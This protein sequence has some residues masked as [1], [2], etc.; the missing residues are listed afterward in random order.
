VPRLP[1][2]LVALLALASGCSAGEMRT[3]RAPTPPGTARVVR[4]VDGDTVVVDIDGR[5]EPVRLIGIDTPE[6]VAE[7]RPVECYGP[8]A[9]DRMAAL[10]RRG[11]L[12]RLERDVEARDRYDRLLAYVVR[13]EDGLFVNERLVEE[14][15]AESIAYPPNT[16]RQAELDRAEAEAR[17]AQRGLWAACGGTDVPLAPG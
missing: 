9:K 5:D 10:L 14:G 12:V 4:P 2:A 11:T 15:F 7:G 1:I 3:E 16:A 17:D 6:S 8:E 13:A